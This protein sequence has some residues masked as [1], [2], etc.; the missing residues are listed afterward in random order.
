M[1]QDTLTQNGMTGDASTHLD[2]NQGGY[3]LLVMLRRIRRVRHVDTH[4]GAKYVIPTPL[5][6]GF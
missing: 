5:F 4:I 6:H 3:D 2:A 1:L